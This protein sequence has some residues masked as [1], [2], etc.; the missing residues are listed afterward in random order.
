MGLAF[1]AIAFDIIGQAERYL[2]ILLGS[3]LYK[4]E[5]PCVCYAVFQTRLGDAAPLLAF[6]AIV[7][8]EFLG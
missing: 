3:N 7:Q 6:C 5:E 4:S 1:L 2:G 8:L